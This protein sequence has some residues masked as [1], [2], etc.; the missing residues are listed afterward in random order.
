MKMASAHTLHTLEQEPKHSMLGVIITRPTTL[1][2]LVL[3]LTVVYKFG[4]QYLYIH[5]RPPK[6]LKRVPGPVSTIPFLG[7]LHGVD[8]TAPWKSM[9]TFSNQYNKMFS[10]VAY[11]QQHIWIGDSRIAK[12][13]LV[14][15]AAKYSSRPNIAAI[16]GADKGG[17]Y[18]ALNQND[19]HWRLQR[20]FAHTV[21]AAAHQSKYYGSTLR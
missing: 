11:G 16:P 10:L 15:R 17:Q 18:L 2:L 3:L 8:P 19:E 21:F 6:G 4:Y 14:R 13:L 1:T 7:R 20:R 5:D 9:H 12:E